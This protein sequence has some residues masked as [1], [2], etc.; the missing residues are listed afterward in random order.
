[1]LKML[2]IIRGMKQSCKFRVSVL[3][4]TYAGKTLNFFSEKHFRPRWIMRPSSPLEE[5]HGILQTPLL[6]ICSFASRNNHGLFFEVSSL[7]E[8]LR[9]VGQLYF[10]VDGGCV[11]PGECG[12]VKT[13]TCNFSLDSWHPWRNGGWR[14]CSCET[15]ENIQGVCNVNLVSW[16]SKPLISG[17]NVSCVLS[18]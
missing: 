7:K 1:M 16:H 15:D 10:Q 3:S 13:H 17:S 4:V 14:L 6:S 18:H 5:K 2:G 8:E 9:F 11:G 12:G